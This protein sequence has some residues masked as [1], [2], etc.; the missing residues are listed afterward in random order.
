MMS[1]I[2]IL[3]LLGALLV[4]SLS[5]VGSWMVAK[6]LK[7]TLEGFVNWLDGFMFTHFLPSQNFHD[8]LT[9][10]K[11][12]KKRTL[13]A[14]RISSCNTFFSKIRR[15]CDCFLMVLR[16]FF[17][18]SRSWVIIPIRTYGISSIF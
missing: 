14:V 7:L 16:F 8:L 15:Y 3:F 18:V 5:W 4:E 2:E 1:S 9:F 17:Y 11:K 12:E 10:H 13:F 6:H